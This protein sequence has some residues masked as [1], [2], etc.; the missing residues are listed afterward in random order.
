VGIHQVFV[1][2]GFLLHDQTH[3]ITQPRVATNARAQARRVA[4]AQRT[5]YA[6]ACTLLLGLVRL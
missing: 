5:L 1:R 2:C 6:V 3:T 4:G